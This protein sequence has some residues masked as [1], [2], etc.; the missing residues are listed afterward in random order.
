METK[1]RG[2]P[3]SHRNLP[4]G[5]LRNWKRNRLNCSHPPLFSVLQFW[6]R[7][8]GSDLPFSCVGSRIRQEPTTICRDPDE[9]FH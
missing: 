9:A 3:S 2:G 6:Q 8:P 4:R 7:Q 1:P 5:S